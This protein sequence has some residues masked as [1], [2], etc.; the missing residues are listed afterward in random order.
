MTLPDEISGYIEGRLASS[1]R[2]TR[3]WQA[4]AVAF[5]GL[6][7]VAFV[8]TQLQY[9]GALDSTRSQLAA[10]CETRNANQAVVR[11]TWLTLA[12][13]S[14]DP[15]YSAALRESAGRVKFSD[16]SVYR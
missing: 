5:I 12:T 4:I 3:V 1:R 15:A 6:G 11:D 16:C 7:V 13:L 10:G 9:R 8:L 2:L 14:K